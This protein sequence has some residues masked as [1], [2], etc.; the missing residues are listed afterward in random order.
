MLQVDSV[1]ARREKFGQG[2]STNGVFCEIVGIFCRFND[3]FF[4]FSG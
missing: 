4:V 2:T 1:F 3:A